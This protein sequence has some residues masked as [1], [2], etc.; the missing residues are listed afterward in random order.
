MPGMPGM[1][2]GGQMDPAMMEQMMSNPMVQQVREGEQMGRLSND[3]TVPLCRSLGFCA[4]GLGLK[5]P[6]DECLDHF[7]IACLPARKPASYL[8]A[9]QVIEVLDCWGDEG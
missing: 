3:I 9:V 2:G 1:P 6:H 8:S 4:W 5:L 7:C